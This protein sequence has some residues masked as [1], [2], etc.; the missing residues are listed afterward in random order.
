VQVQSETPSATATIELDHNTAETDLGLT[1]GAGVPQSAPAWQQSVNLA[2]SLD[3]LVPSGSSDLLRYRVSVP[4]FGATALPPA[5]QNPWWIRAMEGGNAQRSGFL[6][7][8]SMTVGTVVYETDSTTPQPTI[9]GGAVS[10]WIPEPASVGIPG[11]SHPGVRLLAF[12]NPFRSSTAFEVDKVNGPVRVSIHDLAG[13][14]VREL[15]R[16]EGT[17]RQ[18]MWD[19]RDALGTHVPSG[20]Y[21]LRIEDRAQVRALRLVKLP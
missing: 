15:W 12:P 10:L 9:E 19:G 4:V 6:R 3:A 17:P 14:E 5:P 20:T 18:L 13:R 11:D 1:L 21:F 8:F 7:D 16:G 2:S